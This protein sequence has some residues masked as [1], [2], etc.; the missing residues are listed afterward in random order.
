MVVLLFGEG[1]GGS[2]PGHR[3]KGVGSG[4]QNL[5]SLLG[6]VSMLQQNSGFF[7]LISMLFIFKTGAFMFLQSGLLY[8]CGNHCFGT[9]ETHSAAFEDAT[10]EPFGHGKATTRLRAG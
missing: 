10:T 8:S 3:A 7:N 6:A 5:T 9:V 4:N 2:G 1:R